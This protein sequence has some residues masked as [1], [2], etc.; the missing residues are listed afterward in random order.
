MKREEGL[1]ESR[2]KCFEGEKGKGQSND[3]R[4]RQISGGESEDK[5]SDLSQPVRRIWPQEAEGNGRKREDFWRKGLAS[6][7]RTW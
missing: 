6:K 2:D 5:E 1:S 7:D 4:E 3:L